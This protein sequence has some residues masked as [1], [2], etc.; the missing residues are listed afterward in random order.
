VARLSAVIRG[1]SVRQHAELAARYGAFARETA[2]VAGQALH[3]DVRRSPRAAFLQVAGGDRPEY[4]RLLMRREEDSLIAWSYEWAARCR[5]AVSSA[6]LAATTDE[7][8]VFDRII[9]NFLRM[10]FAHMAIETGGVLLHAAGLV[11]DGRAHIFFGPS[12]SGKTTVTTLSKDCLLLSDD[13]LMI[14]PDPRLGFVATSV[15][16]RGLITPPATT[17]T[18]YPIAGLYRLVQ[19]R[20]HRVEPLSG[21]HRTQAIGQVVQSLPFVMESPDAASKALDVVGDFAESIPVSRLHFSKDAGF[22]KV[23]GRD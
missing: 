6:V 17:R 18:A 12:G 4:Y 11:R 22:W 19:A 23:I 10:A 7:R 20:E 1:L 8:V 13:L 5:F 16:F 3:V 14:A 21:T 2:A 9:E 15:P